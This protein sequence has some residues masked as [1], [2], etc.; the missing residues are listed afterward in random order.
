MTEKPQLIRPTLKLRKEPEML[1]GCKI[2]TNRHG[3]L[4]RDGDQPA[5][6]RQTG[7]KEW[8]CN[9]QLHRTD[10]KPAIIWADGTKE[11]WVAGQRHRA[12]GAAVEQKDGHKEWWRSGELVKVKYA[13]R[14]P[15]AGPVIG[16]FKNGLL[17]NVRGAAVELPN[18]GRLY[19]QNG[20]LH[21]PDGPA[22]L[23]GGAPDKNAWFFCGQF[24]SW[25]LVNHLK[26]AAKAQAAAANQ[27]Q[28]AA[29][30]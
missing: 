3:E 13:V 14:I 23:R 30:A 16:Y 19:Y 26:K 17:H 11:W 25:K 15:A 5:V 9:G 1:P 24:I 10:D 12:V 18:G 22:V 4:H 6:I 8:W 20:L 21:R 7:S 27:D 28:L 29:Q 2:F